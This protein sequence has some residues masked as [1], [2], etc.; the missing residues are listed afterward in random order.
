ML[1]KQPARWFEE[2]VLSQSHNPYPGKFRQHSSCTESR[3]SKRNKVHK[4]LVIDFPS[5][6]QFINRGH[7][8]QIPCQQI[9]VSSTDGKMKSTIPRIHDSSNTSV[10]R[11][12]ASERAKIL[13]VTD[14]FR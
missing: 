5:S 10:E 2:H 12:G 6:K 8:I 11:N 3:S 1:M 4:A 14:V 9:Y 7:K 13:S